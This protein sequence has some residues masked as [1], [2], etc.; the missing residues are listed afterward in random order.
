MELVLRF[1]VVGLLNAAFGYVVFALLIWLGAWTGAAL[2]LAA[3][4]GILFNF[5]TSR[6]LVFRSR[7]DVVR[8]VAVYIVVLTVNWGALYALRRYGMPDLVVQAILT[9]PVAAISFVG[10]RRYVFGRADV[11]G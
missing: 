8:F 11:A 9:L 5:Q 6:R 7:G 4:A 3:A 1:G 10:Q 2:V